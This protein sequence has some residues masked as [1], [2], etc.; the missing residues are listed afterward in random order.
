MMYRFSH[1][2]CYVLFKVLFSSFYSAVLTDS[3]CS[4]GLSKQYLEYQYIIAAIK[5]PLVVL[6]SLIKM[7]EDQYYTVEAYVSGNIDIIADSQ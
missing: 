4:V 1:L 7:L 5:E 2:S 3:V 6:E